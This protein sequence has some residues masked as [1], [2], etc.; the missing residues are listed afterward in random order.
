MVG[1][2]DVE[3][4]SAR[5]GFWFGPSGH[6]DAL[7][8]RARHAVR[9]LERELALVAGGG[10]EIQDAAREAFGDGVSHALA[11]A[12]DLFAADA[13]QRQRRTPGCRACLAKADLHCGVPVCIA[14]DGPFKA[15][16]QQ[17]RVFDMETARTGGVLGGQSAS[18]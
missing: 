13:Q 8:R 4:A 9:I 17:R 5:V 6:R 11:S 2:I 12:I 3:N 18:G 15:Q 16:V 10:F 7:L 1:G 14:L